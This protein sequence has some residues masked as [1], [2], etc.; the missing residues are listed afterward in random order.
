MISFAFTKP[1]YLVLFVMVPIIIMIHFLTLRRKR[2]HALKFANF[3]AIAK[4]KGIDLI[5]KN[6]SILILTLIIA[7]LMVLSL[8][9]LMINREVE[10][11]S[12]SFVVAVDSSNSMEANDLV[13]TRLDAAKEV[14]S[15]FVDKVSPGSEIG[16]VSFSGNSLI[17]TDLTDDTI[18][19]KQAI[20][21]IR[22][23]SV[24][25]TDLHEAVITASNLLE[26]EDA[27][28]VILL[29]D[30]R[31][32]VGTVDDVIL[33]ANR[34]AIVVHT[35]GIGTLEG[36]ETRYAMSKLDEDSLTSI[37]YNTGG[38]YFRVQNRAQLQDSFGD[39]IEF[40]MKKV[41]TNVSHHLLLVAIFLIVL[42]FI[43]INTR[44]KTIP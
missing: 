38:K 24:G 27:K 3:D 28:S 4:I 8:S 9:G 13:P 12:F 17:E 16:I 44:Y 7:S 35:I 39:I 22:L 10:A 25:G 43:L 33:A 30:G 40:K 31:I 29:S 19:L 2:V 21:K 5:S 37:A 42:E 11:S 18:I 36:G 23:S 26:G 1:S 41:A 6:I 14:A 15:S 32:N 20:N 34:K